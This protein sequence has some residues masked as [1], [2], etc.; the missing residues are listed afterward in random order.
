MP[1]WC[2]NQVRFSAFRN[3]EGFQELMRLKEAIERGSPFQEFLPIPP[4]SSTVGGV[5]EQEKLWG[6]KWDLEPLGHDMPLF[7]EEKG[8]VWIGLDYFQTA[9]TPPIPFYEKLVN[10]GIDV[11]AYYLEPEQFYGSYS[12]GNWGVQSFINFKRYSQHFRFDD[13]VQDKELLNHITDLLGDS[14]YL[15][16]FDSEI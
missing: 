1:N 2:R 13:E 10:L 12:A 6:T 7:E 9:W 11:E 15:D 8:K 4:I 3:T 14:A 5:E 16:D